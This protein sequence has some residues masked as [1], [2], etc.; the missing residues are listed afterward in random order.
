VNLLQH[1]PRL[2]CFVW[3]LAACITLLLLVTFTP[4]LWL[5]VMGG[6]L[7]VPSSPAPAEVIAVLAG[8]QQR[9][10]QAVALYKQGLASELWYTGDAPQGEEGFVRNAHLAQQAAIDMGVPAEDIHLL[11]TTSTWEDGQQIAA[12][13]Q[14]RGMRRILVVT[15]W[16]HGRRGLC[17]V[18]RW[19]QGSGIQVSYQAAY[20]A[21]F[22]PDDW[23][24]NEEGL[25]DVTNEYIKIGYYWL[26]YGLAPWQC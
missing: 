18:R 5:A 8:N 1:H 24:H 9:L 20:N 2:G 25:I 7:N 11:P 17:V 22:G 26:H 12:L 15:S 6:W 14:Q 3:L 19:L 4:N 21:T 16:Y 23:W 10:H 13:A